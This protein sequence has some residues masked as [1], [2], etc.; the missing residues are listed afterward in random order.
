[1]YLNSYNLYIYF[2]LAR[3]GIRGRAAARPVSPRAHAC[4][5]DVVLIFDEVKKKKANKL[6]V[7]REL[8]H[9]KSITR[10][11]SC[12]NRRITNINVSHLLL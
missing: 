1:M 2:N 7:M 4:E 6:V 10:L 11:V 3:E 9:H 8:R 5:Y 12:H